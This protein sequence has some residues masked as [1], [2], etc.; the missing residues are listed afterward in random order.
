MFGWL[1]KRPPQTPRVVPDALKRIIESMALATALSTAIADYVKAVKKGDITVPAYKRQG[2]SVVGIWTDTRLEALSLLFGQGA[3]V[4]LLAEHRS[5][6]KLLDALFNDK[7]HLEFPH[8]PSNEPIHDT[9]QAV[10]RVYMYLNDVGSAVGDKETDYATLKLAR[11]TIFS[12]FEN[13]AS[14]LRQQW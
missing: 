10:F 2:D 9:L 14:T 6:E 13:Q 5:Q 3:N 8:Q 1:K 4:M 7:P 12:D 11:K